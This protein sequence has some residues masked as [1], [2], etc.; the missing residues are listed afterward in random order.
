MRTSL[1]LNLTKFW[2]WI[3]PTLSL[4]LLSNSPQRVCVC[5][6]RFWTR[7]CFSLGLWGT[8][9][10]LQVPLFVTGNFYLFLNE[11]YLL[12]IF[13]DEVFLTEFCLYI[14]LSVTSLL[15][16][17]PPPHLSQN[18]W[19]PPPSVRDVIYEHSLSIP[20]RPLRPLDLQAWF[21]GKVYLWIG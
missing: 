9:A 20:L 5:V 13:K 6:F 11:G 17:T 10:F 1:I 14:H 19:P 8:F 2:V 12:E 4:S 3:F 16:L 15:C 7:S 18:G 21:S